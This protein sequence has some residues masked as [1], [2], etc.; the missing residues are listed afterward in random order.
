MDFINSDLSGLHTNYVTD[1]QGVRNFRYV[2]VFLRICIV[3]C[4]CM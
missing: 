4:A 1:T 3:Y 2:F